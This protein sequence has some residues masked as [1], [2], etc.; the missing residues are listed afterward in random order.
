VPTQTEKPISDKLPEDIP[1][2]PA[3]TLKAIRSG[4]TEHLLART[5]FGLLLI[6]HVWALSVGWQS[7][8]LQGNEF[9]Q[10]QTAITTLFVQRENNFSLAYPTPVLGKPWSVPMEFPLYQWTVAVVS[11]VTGL[12]LI[13][14]ARAVSGACLY[15]TLPAL[16]LLFKRLRLTPAQRWIALGAMLTCP[17]YIFYGRAFLIETMALMFSVWFLQSFIAAVEQRSPFW[18]VVA[19]VAGLGA[20]L[21]KVTT[22]MLYLVP[23]GLVGLAW[24]WRAGFI[25]TSHPL[26][27]DRSWR[28]FAIIFGCVTIP[29]LAT[30]WW[31]HLADVIKALNPSGLQ[32]VSGSMS[33]YHFGTWQTRL[34]GDAW[35]AHW[36]IISTNLTSAPGL[37]IFAAVAALYGGKWKKWILAGVVLFLA[38]PAT[39]P[40]LYAWHE[41]YFVANGVFLMAAFGLALSASLE[42][43]APRWLA[44]GAILALHGVQLW[45]YFH[46]LYPTQRLPYEGGS[47]LTRLIRDVTDPNDVLIIAGNDW[48]SVIPFFSERRA[49]MIRKYLDGNPEYLRTAFSNIRDESVPLL[50]LVNDMRENQRLLDQ[51]SQLF[52]IDPTPFLIHKQQTVYVSRAL[53]EEFSKRLFNLSYNDV[54][55]AVPSERRTSDQSQ[56]VS[57][58]RSAQFFIRMT[59][60]PERYQVPFG[61][62]FGFRPDGSRVFDAHAPTR[63]WFKAP[64][65][66]RRLTIEF[67]I[68]EAAYTR[69][70]DRSD[71]VEFTVTEHLAGRP[72]RVLFTRFLNPLER[73]EDRSDQRVELNISVNPQAE[74]IFSTGPGP[75]GSNAFDWAYWKT[76]QLR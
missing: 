58:V 11:S 64:R 70:G 52:N 74:I 51:A 57:A 38:A 17:L 26:R 76:I 8:L 40:I 73:S 54:A 35:L 15:L 16:W 53:R 21:V 44:W 22:F 55:F 7:G 18:M 5:L 47:G 41:Y 14:A 48:S 2:A 69:E 12:P 10:S 3:S 63:L 36:R 19:N 65:D 61:L 6:F 31:I 23:A 9:R 72:D 67:G 42:S 43:T 27:I 29:F 20:G 49:L 68:T 25:R 34:T 56:P 30:F 46:V 45:S 37:V 75:S 33:S 13:Q 60:Q 71:G 24:I 50:I 4:R 28:T 1:P 32:L 62:S 39:F 66:A 59:P